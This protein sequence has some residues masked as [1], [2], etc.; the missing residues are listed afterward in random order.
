MGER[1]VTEE[2]IKGTVKT[3]NDGICHRVFK[4]TNF[5]DKNQGLCVGFAVKQIKGIPDYDVVRICLSGQDKDEN[6]CSH[7][8]MASMTPEEAK[9]V[10]SALISA[11]ALWNVLNTP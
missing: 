10:G 1:E 6:I 8:K 3:G 2:K 11:G 5:K 7:S 9:S 4:L